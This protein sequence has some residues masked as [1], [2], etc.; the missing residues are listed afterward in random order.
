VLLESRAWLR[1]V[2]PYGALLLACAIFAPV[3]VWN[4]EHEWASFL[5]Q[6]SRRLAERPQFALHKL[7]GSM[8]VL[9][10][11]PGFAGVV[12]VL[13]RGRRGAAEGAADGAV[14][15]AAPRRA[16]RF[17]QVSTLVPL[18]VFFLFSLHHE[19]KLDWTG[20]PWIAV[21]PGL[22]RLIALARETADPPAFLRWTRRLWAPTVMG[23]VLLY[24]VGF[25]ELAVGIP[26]VGYARHAELEPVGWRQLGREVS[27]KADAV[28]R[29]EGREPVVVGMDRYAL[30][31]EL[32]F[33]GSDQAKSVSRASSGHLFGR[34]GLMYERW[35]E[36]KDAEGRTLILV[37][38]SREELSG[39]EIER[40]VES[41]DPI[42]EGRL[43]RGGALI[44]PYY[45]RIARGYR[46]NAILCCTK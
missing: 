37:A 20:A 3:I 21:I 7:V 45:Y 1:R 33:Y 34:I 44:R 35:L 9:L 32:A 15:G 26:H 31:S 25:Y 24:F 38:W 19:V 22:G 23:L 4:A 18:G 13:S 46:G 29:Q 36:P 11:P 30:A 43:T 39:S 10:T 17:V 2:E 41:L 8:L 16:W 28:A 42:E 14:D 12:W 27:E 6:T 5:F 40:R